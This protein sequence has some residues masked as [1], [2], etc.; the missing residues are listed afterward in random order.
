MCV[1]GSRRLLLSLVRPVEGQGV[2]REVD[3]VLAKVKLLVNVPHLGG[4]GIHALEG[5]GVVL[6]EVG[7]ED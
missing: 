1:K 3:D 7:H 5:F 4:F 2:A 6:I